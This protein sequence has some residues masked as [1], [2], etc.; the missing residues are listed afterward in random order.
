LVCEIHI[1]CKFVVERLRANAPFRDGRLDS[2]FC[3]V[4][5]RELR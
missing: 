3:T 1:L 5:I 2:P 4:F